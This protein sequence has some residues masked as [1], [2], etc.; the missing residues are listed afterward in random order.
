LTRN[1]QREIRLNNHCY[2]SASIEKTA[3]KQSVPGTIPS[4][5]YLYTYKKE[6]SWQEHQSDF[7]LRRRKKQFLQ[8]SVRLSLLVIIPSLLVI[9]AWYFLDLK[10]F[11]RQVIKTQASPAQTKAPAPDSL[12]SPKDSLSTVDLKGLIR[13][14]PFLNAEKN[15]FFVDTPKKSYTITTSLDTKLQKNL[16]SAMR[17]LKTL[18]RGKPQRIAIVAIDPDNGKIKAM[19]G[20]D[21]DNPRANPCLAS[22]YPAASII[23][24]ITAAAAVDSLGYTAQ[25]PLYFNGNKYTLY[26]RQLTE[27]KNKYTTKITLARAFAQSINPIFGKLGKNDLGRERLDA[28]A[29]AF[30][31]NQTPDS[32]LEFESGRFSA[33]G[34]EFHLAELGCGFNR[35]TM[36]SPLF[37]AMLV[38][39]ILNSGTS[40]VPHIVDQVATNDGQIIYKGQKASY[41]TPITSRTAKTMITLMETTISKGTAKKSFRGFSRDKILSKLSIG[42]KT[43]SLYNRAGTV[44]YDWFV[45]FGKEKTGNKRL[46]VAIVVGHKKYI[47][48][49]ASRYARKIL[50]TYFKAPPTQKKKKT[51][52]KTG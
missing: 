17:H 33:Q 4:E 23:K 7:I 42:G 44:K 36:I 15:V 39:N 12:L 2:V 11:F 51:G 8:K 5:K 25:T 18:D 6:N 24:I 48:T 10:T 34:S 3:R 13:E 31:F 19:A 27:R 20:F 52:K 43:G 32:E 49:R 28:Y 21:L 1:L 40:L 9:G 29:Q 38:T 47:G 26:K 41:K 46:A 50:K 14:T 16:V 22:D 35:D 37:G 30:G 45:G